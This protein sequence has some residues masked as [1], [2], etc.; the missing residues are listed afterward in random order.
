M[1]KPRTPSLTLP[2][3]APPD[4]NVVLISQSPSLSLQK[5]LDPHPPTSVGFIPMNVIRDIHNYS[6]SSLF[7]GNWWNA[8]LSP[9]KLGMTKWFALANESWAKC[10]PFLDGSFQPGQ[11]TTALGQDD[12][13][14]KCQDGASTGLFHSLT[15]TRS[16]SLS[17]PLPFLTDIIYVWSMNK[18]FLCYATVGSVCYCHRVWPN[19]TD[20]VCLM[21]NNSAL[22]WSTGKL[23][24]STNSVTLQTKKDPPGNRIHTLQK[25][26]YGIFW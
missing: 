23:S 13:G 19:L 25:I 7:S 2:L 5:P 8:F 10:V 15:L 22:P 6:N 26:T 12:V 21:Y 3:T 11:C 9:L 1:V 4:R 18:H 14:S 20:R 16:H 24:Y 17:K